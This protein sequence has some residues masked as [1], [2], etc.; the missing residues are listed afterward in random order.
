MFRLLIK[1]H[2]F[3]FLSFCLG[4]LI[5]YEIEFDNVS[6]ED[7]LQ[8]NVVFALPL[9][10]ASDLMALAIANRENKIPSPIDKLTSSNIE[11]FICLKDPVYIISEQKIKRQDPENLKR[12][13]DLQ[14]E[15][16]L[17]VPV[18][19]VWGKHPDK[20]QSIFKIIFSPSWRTSGSIKKFFKIIFHGRNLLITFQ[21]PLEVDSLVEL[22]NSN[23]KNT[24]L[25]SRYL[26]ALFRK[27]KQAMLGPDISH[28]R[29]MV[30]SLVKNIN[31]REEIN[32]QSN[33][34]KSSKRRLKKKAYKYAREMCSD[35]NYPIV[36]ML[37]RGFTWFWNSRYDGL[38]IRN[39]DHIKS[40]SKDNALVYVP[41][42]RSHI[43]YCALTFILYENGLMLPQI[44]AGNNLNLPIL[45]SILRGAGAIFMRRSFMKNKVYSAVFFEYIKSLMIRGSSIEFFPEG[46]RSRT[47]LSLTPRP[48]LLSLVLRSFASLRGQKVKIVPVYIGYEK[49]LEGQSYLSELSGS[50]KKTESVLDPFKVLKDFNNYLGNAYL[51]FGEPIDLEEFLI[52]NVSKDFH[53]N[54]PFDKPDWLKPTTSLL[55]DTIIRSVNNSVAVSSTSLFAMSLL[56]DPTQTLSKETLKNRISFYIYLIKNSENYKD[57]WLTEV[58]AEE[59][60]DRSERLRFIKN[61]LIGS[62]EVYRPNTSEVA[63]LSFYKNNISHI[64]MLYSLICESV[65]YV[66]EISK[67]EMYK[68]IK[69]V[70]PIFSREYFLKSTHVTHE[71]IDQALTTLLDQGVIGSKTQKIYCKPQDR[72]DLINKYLSL[73]NICEP[74]LKR[75]YITMSVLWE[76]ED[77]SKDMLQTICDSISKNLESIEGWPYPEFSDSMKF[78]NFIEFLIAERYVK[79]DENSGNLSA[80]KITLKAQKSYKTFFDSKFIKLIQN[81]N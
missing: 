54:S 72:D 42:H 55:G 6:K 51:N 75:F 22:S 58:S 17:I 45:G 44:A 32:K 56:T 26:R 4:K 15:K 68:L 29:T 50:K 27:S 31:V 63:A 77:I 16:L 62:D 67:D 57:V 7:L 46:G 73:C 2:I 13:L 34:R 48:G 66:D 78:Q 60:I 21:S 23:E 33:G 64:F 30:R 20:Q 14:K 53:I 52:E 71:E 70:Y 39:I 19:F 24:Q 61:Q 80:S 74:S 43:D 76:K 47:G 81:I 40:I 37:V 59:I 10:S 12:I 36:R 49:I 5:K 3:S 65:R 11:R 28:R 35:L 38:N 18:S 79:K 1:N 25:L 41:C 8:E 9:D 69:M